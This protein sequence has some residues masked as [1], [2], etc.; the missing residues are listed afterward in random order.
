M[1]LPALGVDSKFLKNSHGPC[2]ICGGADRF[3]W[4]NQHDGGGYICNS[5]GAGDGFNLASKVTGKPFVDIAAE[6]ERLLGVERSIIPRAAD[7]EEVQQR[8]AMRRLWEGSGSPSEGGLVSGYLRARIGRPWPSNALREHTGIFSDGRRYPAMVAKVVTH[9]DR[10]VNLHLTLVT[11]GGQKA[12]VEK[13][14][15]VMPGKL[16]DGCAIRLSP[17]AEV[18]GVA[19][20]IETALSASI[21][22]GVP[23]WACINKTILAKWEPPKIARRILIFADNDANFSGQAK[24]YHLANRLAV[25]HKLDV[26]VLIPPEIGE[27]WNDVHRPT[28]P[29]PSLRLVK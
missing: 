3:R 26:E 1:L 23:V 24:A 6:M 7:P 10:A 22:S 17:A 27:D 21:M 12:P 5:C 28:M 2:P 25:Q 20:G 13:P 9:D 29:K 15:R 8:N 16:P 14:R 4:D 19:E 11:E 18:M